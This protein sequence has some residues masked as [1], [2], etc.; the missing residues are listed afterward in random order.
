[1]VSSIFIFNV[2]F[3]TKS[4]Q[5]ICLFCFVKKII[6]LLSLEAMESIN[7]F[8]Y[9]FCYKDNSVVIAGGH[10]VIGPVSA[11]VIHKNYF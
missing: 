6:Q 7:L 1:M 4:R 10:G 11:M 8:I 3:L 5:F 2:F 9:L